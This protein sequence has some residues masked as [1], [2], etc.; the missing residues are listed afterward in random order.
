M[1]ISKLNNLYDGLLKDENF[2][3]L[4]LGLQNPNI[5]QIL[6][7][8][9]TEIRH[10]NFLAWL[11]DANQ[12]HKLGDTFLK[13][14]LRQVFTSEK[15]HDVNQIDVEELDLSKVQILREW[16]NIDI[17]ILLENVVVC[18]ENKVLSK[19][20]SNQLNRYRKIIDEN[21]K[22]YRKTYVFLTPEGDLSDD[23]TEIYEPISYNFIIETLEKIISIYGESVNDQVK[24]YIK[25]YITI[26]KREL[27]KTDQLTILS[28]KIYQN[29]KELLDFI[30]EHKPEV[31]DDL[32]KSMREELPKRNWIEGS[33]NKY[34]VR[35]LTPKIKDLIY[36]NV[37][38]KN[39]WTK[40]ESFLFEIVLYPSS[41]QLTFKTVISPSDP[42]YNC[43]RLE[44]ILLEIDGFSGSKG[45]KW[46]L[47]IIKKEK[48]LYDDIPS[49]SSEEL[50]GI[51]NKFFDKISPV[52]AKVE[53][54]FLEHKNELIKMKDI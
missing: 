12:S 42:E 1:E 17:L 37:E 14:F 34:Y 36:Y 38:T 46:L 50:Q 26:I 44:D 15:F 19:E 5:F 30:Y 48:F 3:R 21:F 29:H 7:I 20:H 43:K 18:I 8:S 39:G 53:E 4:D 32:R 13:R 40:K 10:S 11:L 47:N 25:D 31:V 9:K 28:Q 33:E 24:N 54:K 27:M 51:I 41:N 35:F 6:R 52:I 22:D 45:K 2:D 23:E 49:M 16:K